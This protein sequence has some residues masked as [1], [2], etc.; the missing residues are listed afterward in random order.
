MRQ[1][2]EELMSEARNTP[3]A[4]DIEESATIYGRY[5]APNEVARAQ[6]MRQSAERDGAFVSEGQ[7]QSD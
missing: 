4:D 6:E 5:A 2:Y 3:S 7:R 1:R